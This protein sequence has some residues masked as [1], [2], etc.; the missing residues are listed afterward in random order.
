MNIIIGN[1]IGGAS[2]V[3]LI[4]FIIIICFILSI[5]GW[6][7]FSAIFKIGDGRIT[8]IYEVIVGFFTSL[9]I[10]FILYLIGGLFHV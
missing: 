4:F 9:F 5:V 7:L 8:M 2:I 6:A 10:L 3:A 1:I